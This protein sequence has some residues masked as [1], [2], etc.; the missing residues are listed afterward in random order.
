MT[1]LLRL[2][3]L[4]WLVIGRG[5]GKVF[6]Q[7]EVLWK[8]EPCGHIVATNLGRVPRWASFASLSTTPSSSPYTWSSTS[9]T[10]SG[11]TSAPY[12][13]IISYNIWNIRCIRYNP[14][15][16]DQV[17]APVSQQLSTL[18]PIFSPN[19]IPLFLFPRRSKW[20]DGLTSHGGSP[21]LSK[22]SFCKL[23]NFLLHI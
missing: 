9:T 7:K 22:S 12:S 1:L 15:D 11:S 2:L 16:I 13:L 5:F 18:T 20:G 14:D 3:L 19:Y 23:R 21:A 8:M 17:H 6:L 10:S 4:L